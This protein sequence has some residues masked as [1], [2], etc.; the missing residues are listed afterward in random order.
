MKK[1]QTINCDDCGRDIG[2]KDEL[3]FVDSGDGTVCRSCFAENEGRLPNEGEG[4]VCE[5][6]EKEA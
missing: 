4:S 6:E 3:I 2:T 5:E 1:G